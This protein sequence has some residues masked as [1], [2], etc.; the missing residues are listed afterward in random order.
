MAK[1]VCGRRFYRMCTAR[2]SVSG[3]EKCDAARKKKNGEQ[4]PHEIHVVWTSGLL[5][6]LCVRFPLID[7][8]IMPSYLAH[9]AIV[10]VIRTHTHTHKVIHG[11]TGIGTDHVIYCSRMRSTS[12]I[13]PS[14]GWMPDVFTHTRAKFHS[15]IFPLAIH[16]HSRH[17]H[18]RTAWKWMD[19]RVRY[20]PNALNR[21]LRTL[22]QNRSLALSPHVARAM[23]KW[24]D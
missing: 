15:K 8:V 14:P 1:A 3:D 16:S 21:V 9:P 11:T 5:T 17:S 4:K 10:R 22:A 20:S 24:R 12:N 6:V 18:A 19:G 2:V 7:I 23:I 13:L